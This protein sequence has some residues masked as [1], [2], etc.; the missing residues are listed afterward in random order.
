MFKLKKRVLSL[1][2]ALVLCTTMVLP[3]QAAGGPCSYCGST[4]MQ[5]YLDKTESVRISRPCIHGYSNAED[6]VECIVHYRRYIC[7]DCP[8]I[9]TDESPYYIEEMRRMCRGAM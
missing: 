6:D 7:N 5:F 2:L 8:N 4:N 3:A 1:G 9:M